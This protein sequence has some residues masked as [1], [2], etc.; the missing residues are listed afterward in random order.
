MRLLSLFVI[1][2]FSFITYIWVYIV[3]TVPERYFFNLHF[4]ISIGLMMGTIF[5]YLNQ[6]EKSVNTAT[7]SKGKYPFVL[8]IVLF[9]ILTYFP[10]MPYYV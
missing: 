3:S 1:I 7:N 4:A 2:V 6:G 8:G 9:I 10:I 5:L